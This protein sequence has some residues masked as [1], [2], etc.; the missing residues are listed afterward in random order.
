[1]CVPSKL[2]SVGGGCKMN[3]TCTCT[4]HLCCKVNNVC[5][6]NIL[7]HKVNNACTYTKHVKLII[8]AHT[9]SMSWQK[10]NKAWTYTKHNTA[11]PQLMT[12]PLMASRSYNQNFIKKIWI[13]TA[14]KMSWKFYFKHFY[15]SL[16]KFCSCYFATKDYFFESPHPAGR[17]I[18]H[19][20]LYFWPNEQ[21][22]EH[23]LS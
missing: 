17:C 9:L 22:S 12:I 4:K 7:W 21:C 6:Y 8:L 16:K 11:T 2:I 13:Q 23:V 10:M 19:L 3:N 1:M 5:T 18:F 20:L 15:I 14:I